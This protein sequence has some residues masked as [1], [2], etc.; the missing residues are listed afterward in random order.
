[1][2]EMLAKFRNEG[3]FDIVVDPVIYNDVRCLYISGEYMKYNGEAPAFFCMQCGTEYETY[4]I[5]PEYLEMQ[6]GS[7]SPA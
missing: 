5:P 6:Q 4:R 7:E 2:L 3:L 1:M